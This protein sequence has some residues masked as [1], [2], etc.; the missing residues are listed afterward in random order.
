LKT[1]AF[2]I[3]FFKNPKFCGDTLLHKIEYGIFSPND[4]LTMF[5]SDQRLEIT[6]NRDYHEIFKNP[7]LYN[8]NDQNVSC[9]CFDTRCYPG[10]KLENDVYFGINRVIGGSYRPG[11]GLCRTRVTWLECKSMLK[12]YK[13]FVSGFSQIYF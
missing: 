11:V 10:A 8:L 6:N 7:Y 13:F 3:I 2:N 9:N 12:E 5:V 1:R 4:L